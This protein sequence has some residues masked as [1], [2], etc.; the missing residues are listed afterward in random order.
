VHEP[1]LADAP[2]T[3]DVAMRVVHRFIRQ[4][5]E[6][7]DL[8]AEMIFGLVM[9]LGVTGA[10]RVG[11]T[12]LDNR[13]LLISVTGCNLAWGIVDGV[14]LVLMRLFERG[15][16]ARVVRD[17]R[18][19][20]DDDAAFALVEAE[21][22]EEIREMLDAAERERLRSLALPLLERARPKPVRMKRGDL[23]HGIAAGLVV[24]LPTFP[25]VA[26][27]LVF[28]EPLTAVRVSYAVALTLLFLLGVRWGALVGARPLRIGAALVALGIALVVITISLG[29]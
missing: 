29:G 24:V 13:E 22:S 1:V 3:A 6:A 10:I 28:S 26:P 18:A 7:G 11:T 15:R 27:Y 14:V 9:A 23:L 8:L 4:H 21:L 17:A 25:V 19:A 20:R 12:D 5:L 2:V 16:I